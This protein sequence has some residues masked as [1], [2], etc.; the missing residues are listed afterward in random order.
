M[1]ETRTVKAEIPTLPL[2]CAQPEHPD[3]FR[4][5]DKIVSTPHH[6][7]RFGKTG[8]VSPK[9]SRRLSRSTSGQTLSGEICRSRVN[10][11][12]TSKSSPDTVG[13]HYGRSRAVAHDAHWL[14]CRCLEFGWPRSSQLTP[15]IRDSRVGVPDSCRR[16]S[17]RVVG[18]GA[19]PNHHDFS[20]ARPLSRLAA[21][22]DHTGN[23]PCRRCPRPGRLGHDP[24]R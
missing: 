3:A 13:F 1:P 21:G 11:S 5:A 23:V 22:V 19:S 16:T 6:T 17:P 9:R 24:S 2:L 8:P 20:E 18:F 12:C 7:V 14:V 10:E 4:L 15:G